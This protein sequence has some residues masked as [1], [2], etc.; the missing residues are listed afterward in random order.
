MTEGFT[1]ICWRCGRLG[2]GKFIATSFNDR[3]GGRE[4]ECSNDRACQR[5]AKIAAGQRLSQ[6]LEALVCAVDRF[7]GDPDMQTRYGVIDSAGAVRDEYR[8]QSGT[9]AS[10]THR[11][12]DGTRSTRRR[13]MTAGA[14]LT[15]DTGRGSGFVTGSL[16]PDA[17]AMERRG[18]LVGAFI[19]P[20]DMR[21]CTD[22]E[23]KYIHFLRGQNPNH[24]A[25]MSSTTEF[26]L[27]L[28][29][30][31]RAVIG[32]EEMVLSQGDYVLIHPGT[33]NNTVLEVLD[34]AA[35]LT[36]KAPSDPSAKHVLSQDLQAAAGAAISKP[37]RTRK[38]WGSV[39]LRC[40]HAGALHR[41]VDTAESIDGPYRC[42]EAQ[43]LCKVHRHEHCFEDVDQQQ[44]LRLFPDWPAPL[45]RAGFSA[46]PG[47]APGLKAGA[48]VDPV[49]LRSRLLDV[50]T[51]AGTEPLST[52]EIC[53]RAGFSK[54]EQHSVVTPQLRRFA[55][56]GL[57][58]RSATG[59]GQEAA[60]H[61]DV[62]ATAAY[63]ATLSATSKDKAAGSPWKPRSRVPSKHNEQWDAGFEAL[64]HYLDE[65]GQLPAASYVTAEGFRLGAWVQRQR[66]NYSREQLRSD[67][68]QRLQELDIWRWSNR[69]AAWESSFEALK[70]FISAHGRLPT[71]SGVTTSG[72]Y[73]G[74]WAQHQRTK[75]AKG[76]LDQ[77][78]VDRLEQ[79]EIWTWTVA[80]GAVKANSE[81][82]RL[83]ATAQAARIAQLGDLN[84]YAIP[85]HLREA[86][87]ARRDHPGQNLTYIAGLLGVSKDVYSSRIRRFWQHK[88]IRERTST[89][90]STNDCETEEQDD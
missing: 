6:A 21:H 86:A 44:F 57:I 46:H 81:R 11:G 5:R 2:T 34:D 82:A 56:R 30:T 17:A 28:S 19:D 55:R 8:R 15:G 24:P 48:V 26:T 68:V 38:P 27:I 87:E 33:A 60:W 22:L 18:W 69:D 70:A 4:W 58:N 39:C 41:L 52:S 80:G 83:V 40:R 51:R 1:K 31:V 66:G 29:G 37:V 20:V 47:M 7:R 36:V 90:T 53:R 64:K 23:V 43:C 50:L 54:F 59:R 75:Y 63:F 72:Y 65:Y 85:A 62:D 88:Q 77:Q 32:S 73:I 12:A 74:G 35:L 79:L 71:S 49:T 45:E 78:Y 67:R 89:T 42:R 9:S 14:D 61:L 10:V 16:A 76:Q 25:K 84:D 13:L 3:T